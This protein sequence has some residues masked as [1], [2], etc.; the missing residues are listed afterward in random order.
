MAQL[1]CRAEQAE[2]A[3]Q[4]ALARMEPELRQAQQAESDPV[5]VMDSEAS[6]RMRDAGEELTDEKSGVVALG[7][8]EAEGPASLL[9][10]APA[11]MQGI[12]CDAAACVHGGPW[13]YPAEPG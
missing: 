6:P 10:N 2:A 7:P 11:A 1:R 12:A 5:G 8:P 13:G 4:A 9:R 3:L